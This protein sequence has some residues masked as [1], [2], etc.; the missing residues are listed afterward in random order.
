MCLYYLVA[1]ENGFEE[2]LGMGTEA[3]LLVERAELEKKAVSPPPSGEGRLWGAAA[4]YLVPKDEWDSG[5]CPLIPV[6]FS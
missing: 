1:N 4:Y 5:H 6:D 3:E 2:P